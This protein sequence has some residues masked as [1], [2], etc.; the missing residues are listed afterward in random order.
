MDNYPSRTFHLRNYIGMFKRVKRENVRIF[1]TMPLGN[2][3]RCLSAC[4]VKTTPNST[5]K[6]C[7]LI[8][9]KILDRL[10]IRLN[11]ALHNNVLLLSQFHID[12]SGKA[13]IE[14][15]ASGQRESIES[16]CARTI[17]PLH[18]MSAQTFAFIAV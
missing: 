6:L 1:K 8:D 9:F 16:S 2:T 5:M 12:D 3:S 18:C 15:W 14:H 10:T 11:Y 4:Y 17:N 13:H 7:R